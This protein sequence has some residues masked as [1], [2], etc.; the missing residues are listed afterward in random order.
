MIFPLVALLLI[1]GAG[2]T[3]LSEAR[4]LY[5]QGIYGN[6]AAQKKADAMFTSLYQQRPSDSLIE[7]YYGSLRLLE[8]KRTWA[9]WRKNALSRE[10]V[11]RMNR[12]VSKTPDNLEIRF[13]RAATEYNLPAFFGLTQQC[14][15]DF[16]YLAS[17]VVQAA[18]NGSLDPKLAAASLYYYGVLRKQDSNF[19][20]AREAWRKA[21]S[22]A[23][24]SHAGE[25][26][27]RELKALSS[28]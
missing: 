1:S 2:A 7:V 25:S 23:P 24:D 21:A 22:V 18:R 28:P 26:A 6:A 4:A 9:L 11:A 10:G 17:R 12:A 5:Y 19:A 8:A 3:A 15:K 14:R 16:E 13:V 27:A 20:D